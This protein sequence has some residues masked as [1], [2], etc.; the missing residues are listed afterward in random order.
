MTTEEVTKVL[1]SMM[2]ELRKLQ[3]GFSPSALAF[4]SRWEDAIAAAG[5]FQNGNS[6][7]ALYHFASDLA[8]L[9]TPKV[10]ETP[11]KVVNWTNP[12][13]SGV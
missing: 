6:V 9:T 3:G 4:Y 8:A 13:A 2:E 7:A 5:R 10:A 12:E 11:A 1:D